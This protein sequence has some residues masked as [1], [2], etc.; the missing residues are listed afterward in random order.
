MEWWN[1]EKLL[2]FCFLFVYSYLVVFRGLGAF[3]LTNSVTI[4]PEYKETVYG[5]YGNGNQ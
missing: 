3:I 4:G 1:Y 5:S 2:Q